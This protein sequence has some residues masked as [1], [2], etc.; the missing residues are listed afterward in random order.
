MPR[1]GLTPGVPRLFPTASCRRDLGPRTQDLG[2]AKAWRL[3]PT[4]NRELT[5]RTPVRLHMD[6]KVQGPKSRV[7][8]PRGA[9]RRAYFN[10]VMKPGS[11]HWLFKLPGFE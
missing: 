7:Q 8:S 5:Q 11:D 9:P 3:P 4:E 10:S 1:H 6:M 2:P